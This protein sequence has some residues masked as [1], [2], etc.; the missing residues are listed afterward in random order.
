MPLSF[1][2]PLDNL[3][4][5]QGRTPKPADFDA[6]WDA[7]VAE[8]AQVDPD[9]RLAPAGF[10]T[11]AADC[12][13]LTFTG[14]GGARVHARL[15]QPKATTAPH[16]AVLMFH[17]YRGRAGDWVSMLGYASEG[18]TVAALD[19][20]GQGGLS[21]DV[22]GVRGTTLQG[23]IIRGLD[24]PP[25]QMFFR[26]I[27]LDT[28]QLARIV[29]EMPQ[30]DANRVGA[31]GASQGGGLTLACAAL[32]PRIRLAAPTYPFLCDYQ[33][34]WE[35]DLAENAY[36]E[37]RDYF[38]RFDPRHAREGAIFTQ[39]GY[40][41]VQHLAARVRAEV[42]LTVCLMDTVCPPSTQFAAYNKLVG[43]RSLLLYP[44]YAH[45]TPPEHAEQVF[46]FMRRLTRA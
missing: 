23:H 44:D 33:R 32:E 21:E 14:V 43:A 10:E 36:A 40:I 42:L 15:L 11:A 16:P 41:D 29:M 4:T 9:V 27:F 1:D 13:H 30:V 26:Q 6:F 3:L 17:G 46:Q 7:A 18:F 37:L 45:E 39:L 35:L 22:G 19:C 12:Y 5:Y 24:G 31:L 20:R 25:E 8:M 2:M 38:R 28:A 34:V